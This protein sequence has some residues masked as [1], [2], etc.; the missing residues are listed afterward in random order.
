MLEVLG[1]LAV[2]GLIGMIV[3]RVRAPVM[4]RHKW[5]QAARQLRMFESREN[6]WRGKVD[7]FD[8]E[9]DLNGQSV[10]VT[11]TGGAV[12]EAFAWLPPVKGAGDRDV[13]HAIGDPVFDREV[14]V[15]GD[16]V[17]ALAYAAPGLRGAFVGACQRGWSLADGALRVAV[18]EVSDEGPRETLERGLGLARVLVAGPAELAERLARRFEVEP[19]ATVRE[20]CVK[21]LAKLAPRPTA[22]DRVLEKARVDAAP[23][24]RVA[25]AVVAHDRGLLERL[26]HDDGGDEAVRVR[27]FEALCE[28]FVEG[29]VRGVVSAWARRL[30]DGVGGRVALAKALATIEIPERE[31]ALVKLV[32]D[33]PEPVRLFA[34]KALARHGTARALGVLRPIKERVLASDVREAANDAVLAIQARSHGGERGQLALVGEAGG[35]SLAGERLSAGGESRRPSRRLPARGR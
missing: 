16:R 17:A 12:P 18:G 2:S 28:G 14:R 20:A 5:R 11:I 32:E 22:L 13:D 34:C 30:P 26:I 25:A 31:E 10:G 33:G 4:R 23:E 15:E 35:L 9:L 6:V 3:R 19:L 29:E 1:V 27:A 21:A 24:V 7:G 8:L